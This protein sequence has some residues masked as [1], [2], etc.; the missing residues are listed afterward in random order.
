M[1]RKKEQSDAAPKKTR[2]TGPTKTRTID[3]SG[4]LRPEALQ[5]PMIQRQLASRSPKESVF[6]K[7]IL[8]L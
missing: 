6:L 8:F 4:R 2:S 5:S 1:P 7:N 3:D